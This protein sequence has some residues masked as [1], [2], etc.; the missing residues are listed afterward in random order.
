MHFFNRLLVQQPPRCLRRCCD[1]RRLASAPNF[2]PATRYFSLSYVRRLLQL[3]LRQRSSHRQCSE[4]RTDRRSNQAHIRLST[5]VES[6]TFVLAD[7]DRVIVDLPQ[8]DF[9]LDRRA[10]NQH[11]VRTAKPASSRRS[12]LGN[13]L[14]ESRVLSLI[15]APQPGPASGLRKKRCDGHTSLVIDSPRRIVR[16][17][18]PRFK[19]RGCSW[20]RWR[21]RKRTKTQPA[22]VKP[23]VM[24]DRA[25]AES[26]EARW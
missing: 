16:I 24:I 22:S 5:S 20:G 19:S 21:K 10:A 9:L 14:R 4:D 18:V 7:P 17:S 6:T 2:Y 1:R 15:F 11:T 25:M 26:T 3:H 13:S 12:D 8:T 23:V